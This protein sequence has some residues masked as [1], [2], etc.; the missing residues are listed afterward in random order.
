MAYRPLEAD[1]AA[2]IDRKLR[3]AEVCLEQAL[4]AGSTDKQEAVQDAMRLVS[5]ARA[6]TAAKVE[7][8]GMK[9][10]RAAVEE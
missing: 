2:R 7:N 5:E 3:Q 10:Y 4:E 9:S 1:D 6:C 8:S